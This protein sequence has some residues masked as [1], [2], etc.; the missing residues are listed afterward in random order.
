MGASWCGCTP[1]EPSTVQVGEV[2]KLNIQ[3]G[4]A[5]PGGCKKCVRT[6]NLKKPSLG[7]TATQKDVPTP[8][9][10]GK[11]RA[12]MK[13][14]GPAG[15]PLQAG[16]QLDAVQYFQRGE[17]TD[18]VAAYVDSANAV[19]RRGPLLSPIPN[20]IQ[21]AKRDEGMISE[22]TTDTGRVMSEPSR[23]EQ[24]RRLQ[25][26][27]GRLKDGDTASAESSSPPTARTVTAT[28]DD[29]NARETTY[30]TGWND[31][32]AR[33]GGSSGTEQV[34]PAEIRDST[35]N[36]EQK[37]ANREQRAAKYKKPAE[38]LGR[39]GA[40]QRARAGTSHVGGV[41]GALQCE[42]R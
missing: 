4:V 32:K 21:C 26:L 24:E 35:T 7:M 5:T 8:N 28:V 37:E 31:N 23:A 40:P 2:Q 3:H 11:C 33:P 38:K 17:P 1:E 36:K 15:E 6:D 41:R 25:V 12:S 10:E 16:W 20:R 22:P 42:K 34:K 18:R 27:I 30:K 13:Q 19:R 39:P 9:M 29:N 14:G